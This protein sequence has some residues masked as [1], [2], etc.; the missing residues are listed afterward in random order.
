MLAVKCQVS[1]Y[2]FSTSKFQFSA[3]MQLRHFFGCF[4]SNSYM[5]VTCCDYYFGILGYHS[6][7][8]SFILIYFHEPVAENKFSDLPS[9]TF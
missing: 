2:G 5:L 8:V 9:F 4:I 7:I 6:N 1:T 3:G